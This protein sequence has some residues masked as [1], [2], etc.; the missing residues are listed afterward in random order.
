M[1]NND[2][3]HNMTDHDL[4]VTLAA[5]MG[6]LHGDFTGLRTELSSYRLEVGSQIQA[7]NKAIQDLQNA[8]AKMSGVL[9]ALRWLIALVGVIGG[10]AGPVVA[11][12]VA[13]R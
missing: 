6:G 9:E 5:T 10:I 11:W 13:K 4:L 2:Q 1:N 7:H 12:L 3:H 8:N